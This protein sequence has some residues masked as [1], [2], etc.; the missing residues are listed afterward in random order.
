MFWD[1]TYEVDGAGYNLL[2]SKIA[3]GS[4]GF[5]GKGF[6]QGTQTRLDFL[7]K[8]HTDFTFA[9][10]AEDWGFLG[11][12]VFFLLFLALIYLCLQIARQ[13][14]DY[15]G[16]L[17]A[18]GVAMYFLTH[19]AINAGMAMGMLPV[20]GLPLSFRAHGQSHHPQKPGWS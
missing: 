3:I 19:F 11:C 12:I 13:C 16:G 15:S 9:V 17:L 7:P 8:Y 4:G 2:Q 6:G 18:A 20:A 10:L 1:P 14:R 5:F